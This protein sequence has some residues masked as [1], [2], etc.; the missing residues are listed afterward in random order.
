L[1]ELPLETYIFVN[2]KLLYCY[3]ALRIYFR[4]NYRTVESI[5]N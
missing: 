5:K 4:E 1:V 2:M 3:I